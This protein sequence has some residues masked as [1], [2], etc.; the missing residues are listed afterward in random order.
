MNEPFPMAAI[1]RTA[2]IAGAVPSMGMRLPLV[3]VILTAHNYGRFLEASIGSVFGQS[4]LDVECIVVDD[5]SSDETPRVLAAAAQTAGAALTAIR[6]ER[7]LGQGATSRIGFEAS[8][9]QY[10]VFMDADDLLDP[11]F[12]RDHIF[13]HLSSRM[14]VGVSTSDIYQ[15]VDN[16]IV[17]ATNEAFANA[18]LR[19]P[20]QPDLFRP[21]A[22]QP[23]GP[24][25]FDGPETAILGDVRLIPPGQTEWQ[26][27]PMTAN[28]FRR[29]ALDLL[30]GPELDG[31]RLSTD[32][33]LCTGAGVLC[34]S[35]LIDKPLS[36]YRIHG[37]NCGTYQAQLTNM[38]A[39]RAE[40]ELSRRAK[41]QLVERFTGAA[42]EICARLWRPEP[43]LTALRALETDLAQ[44]G[45]PSF[46]AECLKRHQ[47]AM[48]SAV[49][50]K[51]LDA[52]NA[53]RAFAR[54][55]RWSRQPASNGV[56]EPR[57]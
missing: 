32:V 46:V 40:S 8:R 1:M 5:G 12:V 53:R 29:D 42:P 44:C 57:Q 36:Y 47:A 21:L 55:F 20:P 27:S 7:P 38:R 43:L 56:K 3:S 34:G 35:V 49:G 51:K 24:W 11:D 28:M 18:V 9:G 4:Y 14:P 31:L 23:I 10:V 26:W 41:E 22:T 30:I 54:R 17:V 45:A 37:E 52:W 16:R 15:A 39:V 6:N 25:L 2:T 48:A 50:D 13:V 33:Y 19:T